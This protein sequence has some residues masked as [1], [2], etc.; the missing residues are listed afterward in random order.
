MRLLLPLITVLLLAAGLV[1]VG[2][3]HAE[4]QRRMLGY[5]PTP[6]Q[7]TAAQIV[8]H[9]L[10]G[11][12]PRVEY[13]YQHDRRA[14]Q[15][16]RHM[17]LSARGSLIRAQ[18]LIEP[19]QVGESTTAYVDPHRPTRAFLVAEARFYPYVLMLSPIVG[20]ALL[21]AGLA[22]GGCF[23]PQPQAIRHGPFDWYH[24][25]AAARTAWRMH[26]VALGL[27]AWYLY[28][29]AALGHY[30]TVSAFVLDQTPAALLL[31]A[32]ALA[33]LPMLT[34]LL[35]HRRVA[36]LLDDAELAATLPSF[37]TDGLVNLR[38]AQRVLKDVEIDDAVLSLVCAQR[39][40]PF[41]FERMFVHSR[42]LASDTLLRG[43]Q[44]L[45]A[46]GQ[47][48]IPPRK[49]RPSS[50]C[51]RWHY[52][53]TDWFVEVDIHL[54]AGGRYRVRYP[55]RVEPESQAASQTGQQ[56]GQQAA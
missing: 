7:I 56:A 54:A 26:I 51:S 30:L 49:R 36:R 11:Y 17:P 28:A 47:F 12:E 22:R 31:I 23:E 53:R 18:R 27:G 5:Q 21:I 33:G 29:L 3:S 42:E 34:V 39:R 10:G 13:Q 44:Q 9:P 43:G 8:R 55:I 20:L 50:T 41:H 38:L 35:R 16:R 52:P 15:G 37:R 1:T 45:I 46:E 14:Y 24:I 32:Y 48:E 2:W 4:R 25:P 40:G 6:A 19:Y